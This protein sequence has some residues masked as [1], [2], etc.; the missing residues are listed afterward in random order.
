MMQTLEVNWPQLEIREYEGKW[1]LFLGDT[2]IGT[3]KLQ[4]DAQ[5]T[6]NILTD[7]RQEYAVKV[8]QLALDKKDDLYLR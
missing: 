1:G 6:K 3:S 5:L 4:C 2:L 8:A 7:W